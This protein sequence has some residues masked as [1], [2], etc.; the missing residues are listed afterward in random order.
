M[1]TSKIQERAGNGGLELLNWMMMA[2]T[3]PEAK[4]EKVFYEPMPAWQTGLGGIL[5][6]L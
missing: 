1:T 5:M 3:V 6:T 4:G 2:G